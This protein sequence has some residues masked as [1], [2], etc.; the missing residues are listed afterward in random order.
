[1][2]T[3]STDIAKA[4]TWRHRAL[5]SAIM[6]ALMAMAGAA[7]AGTPDVPSPARLPDAGIAAAGAAAPQDVAGDEDKASRD[8]PPQEAG[9]VVELGAIQVTATGRAQKEVDV[10]YNISVV[11]GDALQANHVL[12]NAELFRSIPG[13]NVVDSG[14]RNAAAVNNIRIRG[15]N[16]DSS[17]MGDYAVTSV[18]PVATYIDSVPLYANFLLFDI[19]RVEVLRG[20]QGT[21]YGSGSLGGTV[22][23]MLNKPQL[24]R[25]S[26]SVSGS[27]SSAKSSSS[28]GNS[29][30]VVLNVPLGKT[31]AARF[32]GQRNDFPGVTDYVNLYKLDANGVPAAPHGV[33]STD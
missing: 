7:R 33:L 28:I 22:R 13:V 20:P 1:M 11:T 25:F 16:V 8:K 3:P 2:T 12:D 15:I 17:A 19:D 14:P 21:L 10:P 23:Y 27:L 32:D 5:P 31:L 30:S 26:G 9:K 6:V 24:D 29:E 4:R 18:A